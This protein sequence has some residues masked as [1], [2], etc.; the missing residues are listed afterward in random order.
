MHMLKKTGRGKILLLCCIFLFLT[1][2]CWGARETDELG[3]I[4]AMGIDKGK[5]SELHI[6]FQIAILGGGGDKISGEKGTE[7]YTIEAASVFGALQLANAFASK[8]LTLIHNRAVVVSDEIA[9][10]G[11]GEYINTF[12]RSREIR[13]NTF[14]FVTPGQAANVL[15]NNKPLLESNPS[16]QLELIMGAENFAGFIPTTSIHE[17]NTAMKSPGRE[18][19]AALIGVN[20]GKET[21]K[22][23]QGLEEKIREEV[24]YLPGQIP[25]QGGNKIDIIGLAVF[26][27]DKLV[28]YLDGSQTRYY[29]MVKGSF[30]SAIF[31][32]PDPR[33]PEEFVLEIK[34]KKGRNPAIKAKFVD[35]IPQIEVSLFLEAEIISI[36]SGIDYET[37]KMEHELEQY[38][39]RYITAEISKLVSKT[40]EE[41]QSDIFGFGEYTRKN[42]LT[43]QKWQDYDWLGKYPD[44]QISVN[45]NLAIRRTGLMSNTTELPA[46]KKEGEKVNE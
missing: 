30:N 25:R 14:L 1:T 39:E 15:K 7:L 31:T 4:L 40:Q 43:W 27:G 28:G 44:A 11:L 37:G 29:Q 22:K 6:T 34:I 17:I 3:Y 20:E 12:I 32:F 21:E 23:D 2:G 38:L 41:Y 5:E 35:N 13:R 10:E 26:K 36:A 16:R 33:K 45:T 9:K 42:F 19:V 24:A 8:N 18:A 46:N